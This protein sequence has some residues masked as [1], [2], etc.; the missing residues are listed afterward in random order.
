MA[1]FKVGD[2]VVPINKNFED[3][4]CS[5]YYDN[6]KRAAYSIITSVTHGGTY[7]FDTYDNEDQK[8]DSCCGCLRDG[9]IEYYKEETQLNT[10]RRTFRLIKETAST[11]KGALFQERCDDGTQPYDLITPEFSKSED[12]STQKV[13]ILDR[14]LVEDQPKWFEEVF[15]TQPPFMNK[16]EIE[17][18]DAFKKS[19]TT[20]AKTTKKN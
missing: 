2:K 13:A 5:T 1:E 3:A 15:A 8:F 4:R 19:R 7:Y 18:F 14:S 20:K 17:A 9:E 11:N 16:A 10:T 12:T 6:V